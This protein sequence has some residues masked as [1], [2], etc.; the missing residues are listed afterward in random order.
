MVALSL[1]ARCPGEYIYCDSQ[2]L[3]EIESL[4]LGGRYRNRE[5]TGAQA[6]SAEQWGRI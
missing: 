5:A 4:A 6:M 1:P 3:I 2:I